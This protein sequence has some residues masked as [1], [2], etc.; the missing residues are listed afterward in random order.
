MFVLDSSTSIGRN[1]FQT[2]KNFVNTFVNSLEIGPTRS[3]VGVIIFSTGASVQFN[4]DTYSD[5]ESLTDAVNAIQYTGGGTNTASALNLL[6]SNGFIGA[7]P[8]SEAVPRVAIVVTDGMSNSAE[9]TETAAEALQQN[10]SSITIYAVGISGANL[11]ELNVI[12]SAPNLVR[13]ISSFA[14][15]EIEMLQEDLNEQACTG[16][17]S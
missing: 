5:R 15:N 3:Q 2:M 13:F 1:N 11:Q 14:A 4:L 17:Y 10:Q 7:R 12:A 8:E 16:M 9:A 6:A